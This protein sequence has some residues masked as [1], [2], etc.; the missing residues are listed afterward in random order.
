MWWESF[1]GHV[2]VSSDFYND[3]YNYIGVIIIII[4]SNGNFSPLKIIISYNYIVHNNFI[5]ILVGL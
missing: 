2:A 5:P 1:C 3:N 4:T